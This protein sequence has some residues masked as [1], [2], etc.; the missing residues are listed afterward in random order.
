MNDAVAGLRVAKRALSCLAQL[1][2]ECDNGASIHAPLR[3]DGLKRR[4][5][6]MLGVFALCGHWALY[7]LPACDLPD[8]AVLSDTVIHNRRRLVPSEGQ[9]SG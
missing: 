5:T 9:E 4:P 8:S 1:I 2:R 7:L 3:W 6:I